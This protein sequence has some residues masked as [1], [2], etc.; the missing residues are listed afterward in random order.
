MQP[1]IGKHTYLYENNIS[2]YVLSYSQP[3]AVVVVIAIVVVL[4]TFCGPR[5]MH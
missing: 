1:D 3:T 4:F 5:C 2:I